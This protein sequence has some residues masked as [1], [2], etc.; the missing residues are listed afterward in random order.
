[1]RTY[2]HQIKSNF[3][4]M[5]FDICSKIINEKTPPVFMCIGD[6]KFVS[7]CVGP[8]VGHLLT[9]KYNIPAFVYGNLENNITKENA[10]DYYNFIRKNHCNSKIIV[11]DSAMSSLESLGTVSFNTFGALIGGLTGTPTLIGDYSILGNVA[12][13]GI[14]SLMFLRSQK[15][16]NVVSVAEFISH[17]INF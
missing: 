1:M 3:S 10:K 14:N 13:T 5:A 7:D 15:L 2:N 12:T 9:Q 16:K 11:I 4:Q 17:S 8:V 6:S